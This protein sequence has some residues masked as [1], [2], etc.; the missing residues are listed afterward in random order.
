MQQLGCFSPPPMLAF[1]SSP[2]SF[3]APALARPAAALRGAASM[4]LAPP[5]EKSQALPFAERPAKLDGTLVGDVGFD[6]LGLSNI[7]PI[8]W[9]REAELKHGRVCMLAVVGY[10]VVDKGLRAPGA[11]K[12]VAPTP[13]SP[14]TL[15]DPVPKSDERDRSRRRQASPPTTRRCSLATCGPCSSPAASSRSSAPVPSPRHSTA[16]TASRASLR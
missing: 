5:V 6:P 14:G 2:L 12:L 10:I 15:P 7:L 16:V 13:S 3:S 9:M 8:E 1:A 11:E 4:G